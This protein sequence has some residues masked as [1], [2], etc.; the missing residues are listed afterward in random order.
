[1]LP[2][3]LAMLR[4]AHVNT[5]PFISAQAAVFGATMGMW[6]ALIVVRVVA[7]YT[8]YGFDPIREGSPLYLP[9]TRLSA[10]ASVLRVVA[11]LQT[12]VIQV[13]A[14]VKARRESAVNKVSL[15]S[16]KHIQSH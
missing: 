10:A 6:I 13:Y 3:T 11:V 9:S 8:D 2:L 12:T 14:L 16:L 4:L 7:Y 1:M 15:S 5:R